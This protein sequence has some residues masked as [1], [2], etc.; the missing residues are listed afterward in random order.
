[1][2]PRLRSITLGPFSQELRLGLWLPG[3]WPV[4][5]RL[6]PH[7]LE[8]LVFQF[9]MNFWPMDDIFSQDKIQDLPVHLR[10]WYALQLCLMCPHDKLTYS[11]SCNSL[12]YNFG[13]PGWRNLN[14]APLFFP[15]L[16]RV[17]FRAFVHEETMTRGIDFWA[18]Q[19]RRTFLQREL[20]LLN[21]RGILYLTQCAA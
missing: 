14:D 17:E 9:D 7:T 10:S 11:Y 5:R 16:E 12:N 3:P 19:S 13:L 8:E 21:A 6:S 15:G 2:C 18:E 20:P 4:M 1:V